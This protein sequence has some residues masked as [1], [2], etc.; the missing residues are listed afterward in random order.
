MHNVDAAGRSGSGARP[1]AQRDVEQRMRAKAFGQ[2]CEL[3]RIEIEALKVG[4]GRRQLGRQRGLV[5]LQV[6]QGGQG[7]VQRLDESVRQSIRRGIGRALLALQRVPMAVQPVQRALQRG[8]HGGGRAPQRPQ[9]ALLQLGRVHVARALDQV[10]RLVH[11]HG[12]APAI[13]LRE[14]KQQRAG[15]EP[16]VVVA[17]HH[18][19]P[20]RQLLRQVVGTDL[21]LQGHGTHALARQQARAGSVHRRLARRGQAVVE[22]ARQRAGLAV[23]GLVGV[24][25][26][27]VARDEFQHAQRRLGQARAQ[28]LQCVQRQLAPGRLGGQIEH[29]VQPAAGAAGIRRHGAQQREQRAHGLA[30]AGGR[31]RHQAAARAG[32]AVHRLGQ[33]ALAGAEGRHRKGQRAQRLVPG[34]PV[35]GLLRR[36]GGKVP[37]L[38]LEKGLQR[39]GLARLGKDGLL[40][41]V[42][43]VVDQR[44]VPPVAGPAGGRSARRRPGPAPSAAGGGCPAH[45]PGRHGRS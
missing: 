39:C 34:R 31:L 18:I 7:P 27:L 17:H 14:G 44:Q 30:D 12:H 10:V 35:G 37:A 13:H 24:L 32:G 33:F 22:A 29:L 4:P 36:P 9:C 3:Q 28:A 43:V 42:D 38:L 6:G 41:C 11:Q 40:A 45:G 26:G 19:G 5:G 1:G 21:V 20:A 23:A 2:A 8:R 16:V 15:V 25:A